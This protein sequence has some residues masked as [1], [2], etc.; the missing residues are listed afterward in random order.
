MSEDN[1]PSTIKYCQ[2]DYSTYK[3]CDVSANVATIGIKGKV[4]HTFIAV[5][6]L[7]GKNQNWDLLAPDAPQPPRR[8]NERYPSE[9]RKGNFGFPTMRSSQ[10]IRRINIIGAG[11]SYISYQAEVSQS[12]W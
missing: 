10:S 4:S 8:T 2:R 6:G 3:L 1:L 5:G 7:L 9:E 12:R 11:P